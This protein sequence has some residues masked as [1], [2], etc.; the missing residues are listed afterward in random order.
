[1]AI[2][3]EGD[4]LALG[5]VECDAEH[6]AGVSGTFEDGTDEGVLIAIDGLDLAG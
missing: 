4:V 2:A 5:V 3:N 1:V 6:F